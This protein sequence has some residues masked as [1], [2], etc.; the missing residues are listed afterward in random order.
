MIQITNEQIINGA[1]IL[2]INALIFFFPND[3]GVSTIT[4]FNNPFGKCADVRNSVPRSM[5]FL[6]NHENRFC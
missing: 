2:N 3:G 5:I 6:W 4:W 1:L